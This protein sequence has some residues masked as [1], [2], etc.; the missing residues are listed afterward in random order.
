[1]L[2]VLIAPLGLLYKDDQQ[3]LPVLTT[4]LMFL[5]PVVYPMPRSGLAAMLFD[6]NPLAPL[7]NTTR[8][9]LTTGAAPQAGAFFVTLLVSLT[10]LVVFWTAYRVALPHVIARM[11][12]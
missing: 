4:F 10:L 12:N 11:G 6:L 9:W 8:D 7:V 1:M 3:G 2:G 5:T